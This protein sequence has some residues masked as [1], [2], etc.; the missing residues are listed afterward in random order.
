MFAFYAF[1]SVI[2]TYANS[3]EYVTSL[4]VLN[5]T[6]FSSSFYGTNSMKEGTHVRCPPLFL[7]IA[8]SGCGYWIESLTMWPVAAS[9]V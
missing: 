1:L 2:S 4:R 9:T 6:V 7:D 5:M 3:D 8:L